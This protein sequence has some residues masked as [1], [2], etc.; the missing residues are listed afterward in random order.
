MSGR[1]KSLHG[2]FAILIVVH[3]ILTAGILSAS[4]VQVRYKEGLTH[5]FLVLSTLDGTPIAD[6]DLT[7]V[8]QGNRVTSH[9]V[10]HFKDG[11]LQDETTIFSQRRT[12]SLI[13]YRLIQRGPTFPHPTELTIDA[14]SGEVE[15]RQSDDKGN[16]KTEH[17][18][19]KM[20]P[21]LAN[22]L[23]LTLLKNL[24]PDAELP[25]LSLIVATPKPR[26]VKL[27]LR[28]EGKDP[29]TLGGTRR[30]ATH[31]AMKV[32]VGGVAGLV[33]LF[34][35]KEPPDSHVWIN[36]GEI[37]TFVKSETLSYIGGPVWRTELTSPVWSSPKADSD[38]GCAE[39]H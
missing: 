19:M 14:S 3:S 30:E 20:P 18:K 33:A 24:R 37:P 4:T 38:K 35:G 31:Y 34:L 12:F 39:K 11:S 9:L 7:E 6:G 32:E 8:A 22:G 13:S 23:V 25:Q 27:T 16:E 15:V 5:G 2:F 17:E 21:D 10:F 26:I 36:G 29:F 28:R 1:N